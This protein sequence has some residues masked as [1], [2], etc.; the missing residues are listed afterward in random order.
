MDALSLIAQETVY[1]TDTDYGCDI[2]SLDDCECDLYS[3]GIHSSKLNIRLSC[4][5]R[6]AM[7]SLNT[8]LCNVAHQVMLNYETKGE[9]SFREIEYNYKL[10]PPPR[11]KH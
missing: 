10:T 6:Y 1:D 3:S 11:T 8:S 4:F 2:Y 7:V 5:T 9:V